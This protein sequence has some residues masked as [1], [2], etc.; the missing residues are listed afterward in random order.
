M[1]DYW[2]F[3]STRM[4]EVMS[5][6]ESYFGSE[7]SRTDRLQTGLRGYWRFQREQMNSTSEQI[8]DAMRC[9]P[10]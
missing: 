5:D 7:F 10:Q 1:R 4:A 9:K 6:A 8:K 3:Q 2:R